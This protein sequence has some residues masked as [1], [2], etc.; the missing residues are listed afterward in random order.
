[1]L[2]WVR[3]EKDPFES[4][5]HASAGVYLITKCKPPDDM[6]QLEYVTTA[7]SE[8]LGAAVRESGLYAMAEDHEQDI[9]DRANAAKAKPGEYIFII[10]EILEVLGPNKY[11]I[12]PGAMTVHPKEY[13]D[14]LLRFMRLNVGGDN[15]EKVVSF[16]DDKELSASEAVSSPVERPAS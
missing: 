11:K 7:G 2:K 6:L 1:M 10:A 8:L 12:G 15:V 14:L 9:L 16:F 3:S 5:A 4:Q 13:A